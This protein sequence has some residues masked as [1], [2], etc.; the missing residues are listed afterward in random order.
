MKQKITILQMSDLTPLQFKE[1][2]KILIKDNTPYIIN[3]SDK[4]MN[5]PEK[6]KQPF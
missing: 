1:I 4:F 6:S 2:M 3:Y 5:N